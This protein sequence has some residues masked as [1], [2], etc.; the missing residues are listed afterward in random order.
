[1]FDSNDLWKQRFSAYTKEMQRYLRLIFND[2][3][4][5]ALLFLAGGGAFLYQNWLKELPGDFPYVFVICLVVG[6][7]LTYSPI[8]TF[9]KEPDLVFLLPLESRLSPYF[10]KS[11]WYSFILQF[12]GIVIVFAIA[13]PLYFK[14]ANISLQGYIGILVIMS[15]VKGINLQAA[16]QT[17]YHLDK[18][19]H[20][21]DAVVRFS[22]NFLLSFFLFSESDLIYP[23]IVLVVFIALL[24]SYS[25]I[26][27]G[28]ALKW[29]LLIEKEAGRMMTFY[30][31]AN[32]FTDVPKVKNKVRRRSWLSWISEKLPFEQKSAYLYL[33]MNSFFRTSDYLGIYIR[34]LVIGGLAV[35][36]SDFLWFRIPIVLLFI[37]LSGFQ[38]LTL[39]RHNITKIW[40]DLYPI[41]DS[42]KEK[43]FVTL[44]F[45]LLI[46][47]SLVL[48]VISIFVGGVFEGLIVLGCGLLFTYLFTTLYVRKRLSKF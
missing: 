8:R 28:K 5:F 24:W 43:S 30:R 42:V 35:Y 23:L 21:A 37:Y 38:L 22:I 44:L 47:K 27:Q 14:F 29:D 33:Y 11:I 34:L 45:F 46:I 17:H 6:L 25:Y 40:I 7:V 41:E 26:N 36:W 18:K 13:A 3:L 19:V 10:K 20:W 1:M 12:Y 32:L 48:T 39:W 9:L 4:K 2:H 31:V 16:W 15:V